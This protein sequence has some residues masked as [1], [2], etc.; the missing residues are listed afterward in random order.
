MDIK[1][2]RKG[3]CLSVK[4]CGELDHHTAP[5]LRKKLDDAIKNDDIQTM[6]MDLKEL[7]FMDSSGIGLIIGRYKQLKKRGGAIYVKNVCPQTDKL[8][9]VSG[10]YQILRKK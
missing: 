8:L 5:M 7:G 10:M 9:Q 3:S 1:L 4:L 6:V 2:C